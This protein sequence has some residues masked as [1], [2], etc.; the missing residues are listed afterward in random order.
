M[1]GVSFNALREFVWASKRVTQPSHRRS[2]VLKAVFASVRRVY[3]QA[4]ESRPYWF[5][6]STVSGSRAVEGVSQDESRL[7][8]PPQPAHLPPGYPHKLLKTQMLFAQVA[9]CARLLEDC[10]KELLGDVTVEKAL[11]V[12]CKHRHVP[13][14]VVHV[15]TNE[16]GRASC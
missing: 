11:A 16:I 13:Y 3:Q 9:R 7:P 14:G 12:L 5:S 8:P 1:S 10:A 15:E 2:R 6:S 4:Q